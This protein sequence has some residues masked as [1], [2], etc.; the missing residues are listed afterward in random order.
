MLVKPLLSCTLFTANDDTALREI[1]HPG[2][3]DLALRYSFAH[4]RLAPGKTSL[5][6]VLKSVEV[7]YVLEGSGRMEIDGESRRVGVGD[8]VYIPPGSRQ[9]IESLGRDALEF[10]CIVDPAW[11]S[12]DETVIE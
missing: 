12:E 11:R 9:R 1:L 6:H 7:Y 8:T 10:L 2:N 3:E 4:A 5:L